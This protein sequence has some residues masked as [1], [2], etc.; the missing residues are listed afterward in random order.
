MAALMTVEYL[1]KRAAKGD[2]DKFLEVPDR[3]PIVPPVSGS[4]AWT[5]PRKRFLNKNPLHGSQSSF[6]GGGGFL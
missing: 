1:Q 3:V 6:S 5:F 4:A 2:R